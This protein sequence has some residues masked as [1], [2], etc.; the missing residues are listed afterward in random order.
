[1][2]YAYD[3]TSPIHKLWQDDK[4]HVRVICEPAQ[5][6]VMA[7]RPGAMPFV[8]SVSDLLSGKRYQ[9]V[10]RPKAKSVRDALEGAKS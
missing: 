2:S 9:P 8:I 10:I 3:P 7:R 6:Y 5:G 1:M 4:G